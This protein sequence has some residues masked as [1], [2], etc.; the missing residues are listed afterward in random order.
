MNV[1]DECDRDLKVQSLF[2]VNGD[3]EPSRIHMM[4]VE[5]VKYKDE[6][7]G[8]LISSGLRIFNLC[9]MAL[10]SRKSQRPSLSPSEALTCTSSL[11]H[12]GSVFPPWLLPLRHSQPSDMKYGSKGG[13]ARFYFALCLKVRL[14]FA[15]DVL[16]NG[17]LVVLHPNLPSFVPTFE[18]FHNVV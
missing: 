10:C 9:C 15:I 18:G 17:S 8:A 1:D 3:C 6:C 16:F 14:L 5:M 11:F 7:P 13:H 12:S 2:F 4:L